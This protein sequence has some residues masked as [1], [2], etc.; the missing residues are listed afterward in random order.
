MNIVS[1]D[2]VIGAFS[3]EHAAELTGV[4]RRQLREWDRNGLLRPSYGA[5]DTGLPFGRVYSF[6]DLVSLRILAQLRNRFRCT[7]AHL[8]DVQRELSK[9]ADDPWTATTLQVL[10]RRVVITEPGTRKKKEIVG[11]QRVLDIPLRVVITSVREAVARLNERSEDEL[12]KVVHAKFVA[13][14]QPVISGT[15]IPVGAIKSFADA[16]FS[17]EKILE[18][19]PTLTAADVQAAI[20]HQGEHAAA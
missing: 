16:G 2:N 4:S 6:R 11:G 17:I 5:A 8:L 3:E 7:V 15:R 19:Y 13:Q 12:G 18:E 10:G 14:N 9:L 20:S 1:S